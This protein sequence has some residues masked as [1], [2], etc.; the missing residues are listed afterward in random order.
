MKRNLIFLLLFS[1]YAIGS[2]TGGKTGKFF[3][4]TTTK[5]DLFCRNASGL[6]RLGVGSD[7]QVLTADATQS[8]G[9]K[10]AA[11]GGGGGGGTFS[12]PVSSVAHDLVAFSD[13]SG[14]TGEDSGV[15]TSD[16]V[17]K[18]GTQTLTNKTLTS[19]IVGTQITFGN[20]HLEPCENDSGN[21]GTTKTLDL[22]T[23]SVQ[24]STLSG[25]VTYTLSNPV[26]GG[27]YII[28][29]V[30]GASSYTVTWPG[31]VKWSGGTAPIITTTNTKIDLVNLYWDGTS[32]YG[33]YSQN[34]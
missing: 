34:Y 23:C 21:S 4:P 25:N 13:T 9:I 31:T 3:D 30:Q 17:T 6:T 10:W 2:V 33:T 16:V 15:L 11:G 28:K 27:A 1:G 14:A 12:G 18:T 32:Y 22:S 20:Y 24:K 8:C 29:M 19:P 7:T 26:T 5:G